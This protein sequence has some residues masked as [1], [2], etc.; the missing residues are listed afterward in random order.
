MHPVS[1]TRPAAPAG[2]EDGPPPALASLEVALALIEDVRRQSAR[3]PRY[4]FDQPWPI[5]IRLMRLLTPQS[6][7]TRVANYLAEFYGWSLV[8]QG[9]DRGDVTDARGAHY[10]VKVSFVSRNQVNFVQIRP[11]QQITGYRLFVVTPGGDLVRFDLTT[12]QMREEIA[13]SGRLAHGTRRAAAG[14]RRLE[15]AMRFTWSAGT[16]VHDRWMRAYRSPEPT[17]CDLHL[18]HPRCGPGHPARRGRGSARLRRP[19]A[20]PRSPPL[21][22]PPRSP[23]L[24]PPPPRGRTRNRPRQEAGGGRGQWMMMGR[25]VRDDTSPCE[26]EP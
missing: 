2:P 5:F 24:H 19:L 25:P 14:Q 9:A 15:Y 26:G 8:P 18:L 1:R 20:P 7:G 6:Y 10:E 22:A 23:R 4:A 11:H 12:G 3:D 17:P 21:L 16:P 13:A